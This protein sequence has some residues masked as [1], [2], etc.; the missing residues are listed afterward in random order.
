VSL[1]ACSGDALIVMADRLAN[2]QVPRPRT[3]NQRK[4]DRRRRAKEVRRLCNQS[5]D[6]GSGDTLSATAY[7][8]ANHQALPL[9]TRAQKK[10]DK[11]RE[12]NAVAGRRLPFKPPT[13]IDM[14][15][16]FSLHAAA[17]SKLAE[18]SAKRNEVEARKCT[19]VWRAVGNVGI[20][21]PNYVAGSGTPRWAALRLVSCLQ[22]KDRELLL[23]VVEHVRKV[24]V[25]LP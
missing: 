3:E 19:P 24:I 10:N 1:H 11:R 2:D 17:T 4:N 12:K 9:R 13:K 20:Q 23:K 18:N 8:P 6:Q 14:G 16:Q 25:F 7:Q 21:N 15:F 5:N 22:D